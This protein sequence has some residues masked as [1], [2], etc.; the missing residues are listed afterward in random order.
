[1]DR[2]KNLT[3]H[4]I[5]TTWI[6]IAGIFI[7]ILIAVGAYVQA[8]QGKLVP[9]LLYLAFF[10]FLAPPVLI[11][12]IPG[13]LKYLEKMGLGDMNEDPLDPPDG[14]SRWAFILIFAISFCTSAATVMYFTN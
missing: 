8:D 2:D 13:L 10:S 7:L 6:R 3:R 5:P 14:M 9:A 12:R 1:M 11:G 4:P